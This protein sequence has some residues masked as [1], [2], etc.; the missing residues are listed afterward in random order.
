M[1]F[2]K[3]L[4]YGL[5]YLSIFA[6]IGAGVYFVFLVPAPSCFDGIKNQLE[7]GVDCGP[8]VGGECIPCELKSLKV[9]VAEPKAY[10]LSESTSSL[11]VEV[12]NP[13]ANYGLK[14]FDYTLD[15]YTS[16]NFRLRSV[17][18]ESSLYP[19]E[20]KYLV[21]SGLDMEKRR[22]SKVEIIL[23]E[24]NWVPKDQLPARPNISIIDGKVSQSAESVLIAGAVNNNS[25]AKLGSFH[26]V[27]LAFGAEGNPAAASTYE[28]ADLQPF[29]G[30]EFRI[31]LPA[32]PVGKYSTF[33][34]FLEI[35][36]Q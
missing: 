14:R 24:E 3:R 26:V 30:T 6:G 19:S 15:I 17:S 29:S 25:P 36:P 5:L 31:F 34:T 22:I 13:S 23:G 12:E 18:G 8:D 27:A 10:A 9:A 4:F 16:G 20:K 1:S 21:V 33:K 7:T 28:V 11:A 2:L 32:P 35:P